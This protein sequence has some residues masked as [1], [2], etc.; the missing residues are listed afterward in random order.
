MSSY[1]PLFSVLLLLSLVCVWSCRNEQDEKQATLVPK[2]TDKS[3][4]GGTG[5]TDSSSAAAP[6]KT[7]S[8]V[9]IVNTNTAN[10]VNPAKKNATKIKEKSAAATDSDAVAKARTAPA[11]ST[12]NGGNKNPTP[13]SAQPGSGIAINTPFVSKYGTI[14][15]NATTNDMVE[16]F[17][18]FP[19]K[20][21]LIKL[22]FDGP[23]DDEMNGVKAQITRLLRGVGYSNV[24]DQSASIEPQRMPKDIHYELQRNGS[25]I[26]WIPVA[27]AN[28]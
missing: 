23:A 19:D 6:V 21:T 12:D 20:T 5:K 3:P 7:D 17:K 8:G 13:P 9:K 25:V 26:F 14:P 1:K 10:P 11:L 27:S 22:N 24:Q 18:A 15:R 28:Q 4:G 2:D 16:F